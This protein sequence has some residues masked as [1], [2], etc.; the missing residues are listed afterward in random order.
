MHLQGKAAIV[1]GAGRGIGREVALAL[2]R[3]GARV[4]VNDRLDV[5]L[6]TAA[7]GVHLP[8]DGLDVDVARAIGGR[9]LLIGC[10][11]HAVD[12]AVVSATTR[13]TA[14]GLPS[15]LVTTKGSQC[16]SLPPI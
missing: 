7:D 14:S 6:A 2:A 1:T 12:A 15:R 8:E 16:Q 3:E 4:I 13:E 5:A 10:S 11:R 9:Q